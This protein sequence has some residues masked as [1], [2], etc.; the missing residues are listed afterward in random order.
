MTDRR[1]DPRER[2]ACLGV[3]LCAD[4]FAASPGIARAIA[5]L[6]DAGR[7]TATACMTT[8]AH[9]PLWSRRLLAHRGGAD[10]GLHF[11]L[12]D[13]RPLGRM[14]RLA[15][16]GRFPS[17]GGL[18]TRLLAGRVVPD[19]IEAELHR[20]LDAF[21]AALGVPPDFVD[22]H[23]HV[24]QLPIVRD[25]VLR[26]L[27]HR[28]GAGR[29]LRVSHERIDLVRARGVAV[30]RAALIGV[31]GARLAHAARRLGVATNTA[32]VGLYDFDGRDAYRSLF[33]RFLVGIRPGTV[34]LCHPG[35]SEEGAL[36]GDPI[37]GRRIEER[38]FFRSSEFDEVCARAHVTFGRLRR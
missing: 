29:Y 23:Q 26:V 28:L 24:H 10:L 20:Q 9:W 2:G 37:A 18:L 34:V 6:L 15:P 31:P 36:A 8:S 7:V 16:D 25:V 21:Q 12:T 5:E 33:G 4:D 32:L 13:L 11:T 3:S 19:E 30:G 17:F 38:E 35:S 22:G 1:V 14:P 27:S